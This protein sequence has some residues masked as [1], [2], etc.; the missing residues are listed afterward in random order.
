MSFFTIRRKTVILALI[1]VASILIMVALQ[2]R[3]VNDYRLTG[4]IRVLVSDIESNMLTLRR[5]E[6]D[7]LARKDLQ[8][9]RKFMD[10][11][12]VTRQNVQVLR[13]ELH[14]IDIENQSVNH[15]TEI[16][17]AYE[18]RFLALVELQKTIGLNHQDGLYGRLRDSI[19][20]VEKLLATYGQ[21]KLNK[22]MLMLRRHEKDFMLRHDI[23]YMGRFDEDMAV[24][25]AD[26]SKAHLYPQVRS[27]IT[28]ALTAYERDVKALVSATQEM[29]LTSDEGVHGEMRESAHQSE[30]I[31]NKLRKSTLTLEGDAGSEMIEQLIALAGIVL[32]LILSVSWIS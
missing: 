2:Y 25:K 20:K 27:A 17:E 32:V 29:G 9:S 28:T 4:E 11:Y 26:L 10:N 13:S 30:A 6:K 7:F 23:A 24:M 8:Y 18:K 21:D 16:L 1:A 22:D 19:H 3:A 14:E 5:N 31:L 12:Q 15:L